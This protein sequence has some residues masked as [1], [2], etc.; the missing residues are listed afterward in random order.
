MFFHPLITVLGLGFSVNRNCILNAKPRYRYAYA[1]EA[2]SIAINWRAKNKKA[3][4]QLLPYFLSDRLFKVFDE[5]IN[6]F[7]TYTKPY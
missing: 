6:V 7:N 1:L 3:A 4:F 5:I 2:W